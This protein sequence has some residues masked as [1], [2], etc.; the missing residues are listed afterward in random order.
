MPISESVKLP[1]EV[2]LTLYCTSY[3][4][5]IPL[6]V[7]GG[8]HDN[9]TDVER[10]ISTVSERGAVAGPEDIQYDDIVW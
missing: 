10:T 4:M 5:M 2:L 9:I 7:S 8:I 6:G 1:S 3:C